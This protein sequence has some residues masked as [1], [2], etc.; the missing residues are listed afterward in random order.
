MTCYVPLGSK[1][2]QGL[3]S[4]LMTHFCGA[5]LILLQEP[6]TQCGPLIAS[7]NCTRLRG[8]GI[9]R[10]WYSAIPCILYVCFDDAIHGRCN[11]HFV[12]QDFVSTLQNI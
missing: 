2:P 3:L 11:S 4:R 1:R 12:N 8:L 7:G 9:I 10:L 5:R 6:D